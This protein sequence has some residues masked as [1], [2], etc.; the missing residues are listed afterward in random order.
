ME[1]P[2]PRGA[3]LTRPDGPPRIDR[4]PRDRYSAPVTAGR[5]RHLGAVERRL[6]RHPLAG[7]AGIGPDL[8]DKAA[9]AGLVIDGWTVMPFNFGGH[10]GTM[11]QASVSAAEGLKN[12]VN[13]A[14][15]YGDSVAYSR[16]GISSM[17]GKIDESDETVTTADFHTILGY[18]RQHHIARLTFWSVN[19]DRQCAGGLDADS[20]GGVA[21][22][23][24][25][26][27]RIFVQ[28]TG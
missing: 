13:N 25:A 10:T 7:P 1:R 21:R 14:Y 22:A 5:R 6:A 17:N 2:P 15:G 26:Y 19:R 28:Y 4:Y 24:Y 8:I 27:T 18:A 23:A 12:V 11:G 16:I 3:R 20:C 9:A